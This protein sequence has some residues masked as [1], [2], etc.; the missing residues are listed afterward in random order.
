MRPQLKQQFGKV[1]HE[2]GGHVDK[3]FEEFR[4]NQEQRDRAPA[5][6][7]HEHYGGCLYFG[8]YFVLRWEA[9]EHSCVPKRMFP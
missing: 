4:Y 8:F 2:V 3:S 1:V 9:L 7:A 5:R 6:G